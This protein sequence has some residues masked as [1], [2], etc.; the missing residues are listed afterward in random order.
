MKYFRSVVNSE[1]SLEVFYRQQTGFRE[2]FW[3]AMKQHGKPLG[4]TSAPPKTVLAFAEDLMLC[5][6]EDAVRVRIERDLE[7]ARGCHIVSGDVA[8]AADRLRAA[9][10]IPVG[11]N[12]TPFCL[13]AVIVRLR[14]EATIEKFGNAWNTSGL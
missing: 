5:P 8:S 12:E 6:T 7:A 13:L 11:Q 14:C 4:H 2:L 9:I 10:L 1:T 3:R